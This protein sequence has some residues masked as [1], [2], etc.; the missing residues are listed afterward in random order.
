MMKSIAALTVV[1]VSSFG[2]SQADI[3]LLV[4]SASEVSAVTSI[5]SVFQVA[6]AESALAGRPFEEALAF[7]V[8]STGSPLLSADGLTVRWEDGARCFESTFVSDLDWEA[9]QPCSR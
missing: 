7:A 5:R 3:D 4:G 2:V 8:E 9:P 1:A 6:A